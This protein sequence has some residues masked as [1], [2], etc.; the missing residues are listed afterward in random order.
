MSP[1]IEACDYVVCNCVVCKLQ[2][3]LFLSTKIVT[4]IAV[5]GSGSCVFL[6]SKGHRTVI[7]WTHV[8]SAFEAVTYCNV[9]LFLEKNIISN[10]R[11]CIIVCVLLFLHV[12]SDEEMIG[13]VAGPRGSCCGYEAAVVEAA[14]ALATGRQSLQRRTPSPCRRGLCR[15][16]QE[17]DGNP[18]P[19]CTMRSWSW[20]LLQ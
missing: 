16:A 9:I 1:N 18:G 14:P 4:Q 7:S 8:I 10:G 11:C 13:R 17:L 15:R 5:P 19:A 3:W 2:G 6:W 12:R 20:D